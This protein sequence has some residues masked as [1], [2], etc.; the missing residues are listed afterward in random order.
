MGVCSGGA[1]RAPDLYT[2]G[3]AI[4]KLFRGGQ[5]KGETQIPFGND[6]ANI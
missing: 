1:V 6:K 2:G 5:S 3:D 4:G